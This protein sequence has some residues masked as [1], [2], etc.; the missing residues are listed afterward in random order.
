MAIQS[1][2]V[3]DQAIA[4]YSGG[5]DAYA[6]K[7]KLHM[8]DAMGYSNYITRLGQETAAPASIG[9]IKGL[10]PAGIKERI[11]SRF[12]QQ[13]ERVNA[14]GQMAGGID[15]V[16]GNL[17][18]AQVSRERSG[19]GSSSTA[20]GFDNGITFTPKNLLEQK[21]LSYMQNPK[22][23]DGSIKS[24]Q[25]FEA[26]L[27]TPY[28]T[29]DGVGTFDANGDPI[30]ADEIKKAIDSRVPKDFIG[31]EDKY[32]W[33]AQGY[34][35]KQAD[36]LKGGLVYDTMSAPEKVIFQTKNP[37]MAKALD[38]GEVNAGL[39]EDLG[40]VVDQ[41]TGE[42]VPKLTFDQL[43]E[44]YPDT[45]AATLKS[46]AD[47]VMRKSL[48]DD[49]MQFYKENEGDIYGIINTKPTEIF[50]TSSGVEADGGYS[51]FMASKTYKEFKNKLSMVYTNF[52]DQEIDQIIYNTITS[53]K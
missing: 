47:P 16:A 9:D 19:S 1:P 11:S 26:E 13:D 52:S 51:G 30:S 50:K 35:S 46:F 20:D 38:S 33:M 27:N 7:L 3:V 15:S 22:N 31:N 53:P 21:I 28:T 41:K 4:K 24:L 2:S 17:A 39:I 49:A 5:D 40:T 10:S 32:H 6:N 25:Q 44:K 42:T 12:G 34:S 14:L 37:V 23:P 36:A 8:R 18:N 45:P 43:K 48:Q 29:I